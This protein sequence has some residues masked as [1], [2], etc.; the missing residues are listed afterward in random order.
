[1]LGSTLSMTA[2]GAIHFARFGALYNFAMSGLGVRSA[3][4]RTARR[5]RLAGGHPDSIAF[6]C[7]CRDCLSGL[8]AL[9]SMSLRCLFCVRDGFSRT[10]RSPP[11]LVNRGSLGPARRSGMAL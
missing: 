4:F 8:V 1:M 7:R 2:R 3:L 5:R 6:P 11:G 10:F 9:P